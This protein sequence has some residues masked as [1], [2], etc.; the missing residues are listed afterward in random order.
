MATIGAL[1]LWDETPQ[2]SRNF[3]LVSKMVDFGDMYAKKSILGLIINVNQPASAGNF[4]IIIFGREKEEDDF[5]HIGH[6]GS[7]SGSGPKTFHHKIL[8]NSPIAKDI[9][10]YQFML[11]SAYID[12]DVSIN[13]FGIIYRTYRTSSTDS[14]D[15]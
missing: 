4:N 7:S 11:L 6:V 15:E 14:F 8:P 3:K 9:Y 1:R 12:G 2:I 5:Q 10:T 13:D